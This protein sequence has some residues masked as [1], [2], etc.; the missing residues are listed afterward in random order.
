MQLLQQPLDK[1]STAMSL[2][3]ASIQLT[4]ISIEILSGEDEARIGSLAMLN[5]LSP[6]D[7]FVVDIGGGSTEISLI[8]DRRVISAVSFPIGC[9][10]IAA[11]YALGDGP[12]AP[13]RL[14]DIQ[15]EV[16]RLLHAKRNGLPAVP[17]CP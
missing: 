4:G 8:K 6:S 2:F 14:S 10:N 9:V 1:P 7:C 3:C 13:A 15:D 12:V 16:I 11:S 5:S 17:G